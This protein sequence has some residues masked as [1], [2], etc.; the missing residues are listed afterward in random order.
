MAKDYR[1]SDGFIRLHPTSGGAF[2]QF[3]KDK[4]RRA[5]IA[6]L[7]KKINKATDYGRKD[8]TNYE[9]YA[10]DKRKH[11]KER[12]KDHHP[13][14][15]FNPNWHTPMI[16]LTNADKPHKYDDSRSNK[17]LLM[18]ARTVARDI[19]YSTE[20]KNHGSSAKLSD[21]FKD[22]LVKD[23]V[24][25]A[26]KK[27]SKGK[28]K[29]IDVAKI[30][31]NPNEYADEV[32]QILIENKWRPPN[33]RTTTIKEGPSK[34]A[35][36][37]TKPHFKWEQVIHHLVV[38]VIKR[39]V[40]RRVGKHMMGSIPDKGPY[41]AAYRMSR[42]MKLRKG[43]KTF[44]VE[45]DIRKFYDTVDHEILKWII[46]RYI[47]DPTY[48]SLVERIIDAYRSEYSTDFMHPRGL[49]LGN[50][51]SP[52]FTVLYLLDMDAFIE[53]YL[54]HK[55]GI[56]HY[57]RYA[58]NIFLIGK[59]KKDMHRAVIYLREWL[60]YNLRLEIK[61]NWQVYRFEHPVEDVPDYIERA[62]IK[63]KAGD[64][65][66]MKRYRKF[67]ARWKPKTKGRAIDALGFVIHHN[68][69]KV[70]KRIL[71]PMRRLAHR[72]G[73]MVSRCKEPSPDLYASMI[74]RMGYLWKF[75]GRKYYR[76][77]IKPF[78]T[79]NFTKAAVSAYSKKQAKKDADMVDHVMRSITKGRSFEELVKDNVYID[80]IN[81]KGESIIAIDPDLVATKM[82][83]YAEKTNQKKRRRILRRRINQRKAQRKKRKIAR[84]NGTT[85]SAVD[86]DGSTIFTNTNTNT[87]NTKEVI[88][89]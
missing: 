12:N 26:I 81:S 2:E 65:K 14:L 47:S 64:K 36:D 21:V 50:Y 83:K 68:G 7:N 30:L 55:F 67:M 42:W 66:A 60:E 9:T 70:R 57:V 45:L 51:T 56:I 49:P 32:I 75:C 89:K 77:H 63:G 76:R 11:R 62:R 61:D 20:Y 71:K 84:A 37:I 73:A 17:K 10:K 72:L 46:R 54:K 74:S 35:R 19:R 43:K 85:A 34:K 58:D 79:A 18:D 52:W 80:T 8:S 13:G 31:L 88:S 15:I 39:V 25:K 24:V 5:M 33:H 6:G 86:Q 4:K 40:D 3:L 59:N 22:L 1:D 53:H 16:R 48:L 38:E 41:L 29:R 28:R 78:I 87:T 82:L 23:T 44:V 69:V 27:A